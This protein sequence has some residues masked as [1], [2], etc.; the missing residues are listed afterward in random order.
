MP[1][2]LSLLLRVFAALAALAGQV[3]L[4]T[5]VYNRL[6]ASGL[7]SRLVQKAEKS[8]VLTMLVSLLPPL[9]WL[10]SSGRHWLIGGAEPV[11]WVARIWLVICGGMLTYVTLAWL[12]RRL[13]S[14]D[15][16]ALL[17]NETNVLDVESALG[18]RPIG[19]RRTRWQARIPGNQILHIHC[20]KKT[21][22]VNRLPA[23][24]DGLCI[25]QL[26]D[27]HMTGQ[28]M[29]AFF[30]IAID[31]I[32]AWQ[33]DIVAI[34]G[35]LIDRAECMKWIPDTLGRLTSRY[36]VYAILG[37]H[38]Q[39]LADPLRL[40]Q[41]LADCGIVDLG[42]RAQ[43]TN[44]GG[45][46]VLMAGNEC[47][48]FPPAPTIPNSDDAN[49]ADPERPFSILLSHAPDPIHW[50]RRHRFDLLLAGHTHGGQIRFPVIGP[51]VCPSRYGVHYASGLFD[52]APT[53]MHV[54]RGLSGVHTLRFNC[55]PEITLL[56][57]R[58][59]Q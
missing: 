20:Q 42:S 3:A 14:A 26:T 59:R 56:Q 54:S 5:W 27:L 36:G 37:N 50:A 21:I 10:F 53:L 51:V 41:T 32:N 35:D 7:P 58:C 34:T 49:L 38:D 16:D 30:D 15:G 45:V 9:I 43:L 24:L 57:L 28:L 39:R 29:Q 33:P 19:D 17:A 4:W 31:Q 40:R 22:A 6:H 25:A 12:R 55:P 11:P 23:E 2:L 47:P 1:L 8:V 46:D 52:V 44:L 48:W 18:F 13:T